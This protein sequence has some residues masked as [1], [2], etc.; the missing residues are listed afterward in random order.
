MGYQI[1]LTPQDMIK[2]A[3]AAIYCQIHYY[4]EARV[5]P[6]DPEML[7]M[8]WMAQQAVGRYHYQDYSYDVNDWIH[9][10]K[11]DTSDGYEIRCSVK[12]NLW[13]GQSDKPHQRYWLVMPI[14]DNR[15]WLLGSVHREDV[16]H[17]AQPGMRPGSAVISY[18]DLLPHLRQVTRPMEK[19][20]R[21]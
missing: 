4:S 10:G 13:I 12:R 17:L 5:K 21:A 20:I 7:L 14:Q 8:G 1:T 3:T 18:D 19:R 2:A 9:T 15:F 6:R 16:E 11:A